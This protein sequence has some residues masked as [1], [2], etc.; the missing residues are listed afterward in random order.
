MAVLGY[1]CI[2]TN[3]FDRALAFYDQFFGAMGGTQVMP[4]P[5]GV[6]YTLEAGAAVMI[7]RPNDGQDAHPGN[8]TMLAFRVADKAEVSALHGLALSLGAACAGQPGPRGNWGEFAY[9]RDLDGNKLAIF[10][11]EGRA[12]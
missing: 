6:L 11:R 9:V 3:D 1:A 8:G 12:A 2:G 7:V 4:T 5:A 10:H